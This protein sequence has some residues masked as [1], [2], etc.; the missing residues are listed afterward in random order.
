MPWAQ[1]Q[2][3]VHGPRA[4]VSWPLGELATLAKPVVGGL[5]HTLRASTATASGDERDR[6]DRGEDM[7]G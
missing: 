6:D 2:F 3:A 1:S 4:R 5:I 7:E